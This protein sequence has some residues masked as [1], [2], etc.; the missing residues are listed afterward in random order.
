MV[1]AIGHDVG[2]KTGSIPDNSRNRRDRDDESRIEH[3]PRM[4]IS[5]LREDLEVDHGQILGESIQQN[6]PSVEKSQR[7]NSS[8]E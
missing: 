4:R 1:L 7:L 5:L 2:P 8:L 6:V 3:K